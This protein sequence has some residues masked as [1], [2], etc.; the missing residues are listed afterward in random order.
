MKAKQNSELLLVLQ[1]EQKIEAE[2]QEKLMRI[3]D[4]NER[5]KAEKALEP[6]REKARLRI[7]KI[8]E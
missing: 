1:E 2:R 8:R 3:S 5:R 7:E 4:L 6:E